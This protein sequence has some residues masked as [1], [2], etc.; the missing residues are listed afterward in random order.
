MTGNRE[1]GRELC[2][3]M[4]RAVSDLRVRTSEVCQGQGDDAPWLNESKGASGRGARHIGESQEVVQRWQEGRIR[5][6]AVYHGVHPIRPI[7]GC[8]S[9][10]RDTCPYYSVIRKQLPGHGALP[11]DGQPSVHGGVL[12][13]VCPS[14]C[15]IKARSASASPRCVAVECLRRWSF[16]LSYA[17]HSFS[18]RAV[19]IVGVS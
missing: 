15:L 1:A 17:R 12:D 2:H 5:Q 10:S 14:Q 7:L 4:T 13:V 6:S 9:S 16:R 18:P 8:C 19:P 11:T 3:D